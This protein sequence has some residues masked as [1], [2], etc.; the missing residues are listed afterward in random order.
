MRGHMRLSYSRLLRWPG[1]PCWHF[2]EP[3]ARQNTVVIGGR[4]SC[5]HALR[6]FWIEFPPTSFRLYIEFERIGG[7]VCSALVFKNMA[8]AFPH[9][10][11][12]L[13]G[14]DALMQKPKTTPSY[15]AGA[16]LYWC[17]SR[18]CFH[19]HS[20]FLQC[21]RCIRY[22]HL[23][24]NLAVTISLTQNYVPKQ[25]GDIELFSLFSL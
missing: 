23:H 3:E 18:T 13:M 7:Y 11:R 17:E 22:H 6:R 20:L 2:W 12:I 25:F 1:L 16:N 9:I 8:F 10:W 19:C 24:W 5:T 4:V 21:S 15:D 14:V